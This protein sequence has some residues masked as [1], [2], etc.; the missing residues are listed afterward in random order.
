[1]VKIRPVLLG[2]LVCVLVACK[3]AKKPEIADPGVLS[4][5]AEGVTAPSDG[6]ISEVEEQGSTDEIQAQPYLIRSFDAIYTTMSV[7]TGVPESNSSVKQYF[8]NQIS[9]NLPTLNELSSFQGSH[10]AAIT[11]LAAEFCSV[12][13]NL[14]GGTLRFSLYGEINDQLELKTIVADGSSA[15]ARSL[16]R[17]CWGPE[18]AH[19]PSDDPKIIEIQS[20]MSDLLDIVEVN[21]SDANDR[22]KLEAILVGTCTAV[23]S[24]SHVT[25]Y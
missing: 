6:S 18:A 22:Q 21:R 17:K 11:K 3:E 9:V 12:S 7:L 8:D 14:D 19:Y 23:L 5:Q 2:Y 4:D 1:M 20:L 10:Q 24:S 15:I 13:Y 25:I 16:T